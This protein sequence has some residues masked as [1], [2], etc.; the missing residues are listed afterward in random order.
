[1]NR[2][3]RLGTSRP[4]TVIR[5]SSAVALLAPAGVLLWLAW[6]LGGGPA[7]WVYLAGLALALLPGWPVAAYVFGGRHPAAWIAGAALGYPLTGL[8]LWLPLALG[9]AGPVTFAGVW[10]VGTVLLWGVL[11]PRRAARIALPAWTSRDTFAFALVLLLVPLIVGRPFTRI[12]EP[13]AD[14]AR[15][16]RAYFTADFL[17][18]MALTAELEKLERQPHNPYVAGEPL[19]YYWLHFVPPA[20]AATVAGK[21][22]PDRVGRLTINATGTG[23]IFLGSLFL[24]VWASSEARAAA[25][26]LATALAV[27]ASSAEG[28]FLIYDHI[29]VNAPLGLIRNMNVDAV[30]A[31]FFGAFTIDGLQRALLYNPH[32]SMAAA[33]G[34]VALTIAA[35]ADAALMAGVA[36][37]AGVALGL[38]F[39]LS[40]FPGA[41]LVA[42][43]G[44]SCFIQILAS[45]AGLRA[46]V[47]LALS[48]LPVAA[49]FGW[50]VLNQTFEGGPGNLHFG[51]YSA[52][53]AMPVGAL[54][55]AAGPALAP[56]LVGLA[57]LPS[58]W[59]RLLPAASGLGLALCLI[60]FVHLRS[61]MI[62]IGWR[63]GQILLLCA[64]ALSAAGLAALTARSRTAAA[65]FVVAVAAIGLPTTAIDLFN[66]QDVENRARSSGFAWTLRVTPGEWEAFEWLRRRTPKDAVVQVDPITRGRD[67]WTIVPSFAE[68]RMAAG[69]PISL[70]AQP[71]YH[72]LS[73]KVRYLYSTADAAEAWHVARMLQINYLVVGRVERDEYPGIVARLDEATDYFLRRFVNDD[74]HIYRVR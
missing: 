47:R 38:A 63:A 45:R 1:M 4:H 59:R 35:S 73:E 30:T 27:L 24:F 50:C 32:H 52:A 31:W 7:G 9:V 41:C 18:H 8:L 61:E 37:A 14:G 46:I 58:R 48:A 12:G 2:S 15:Q 49:A 22:L 70:L 55:L 17:W 56:A 33:S 71:Q 54:L 42:I 68:R 44:F 20:A 57:V 3:L 67:S 43:F 28:L 39:M 53:R 62:W 25:A 13:D 72:E 40:P 5:P 16:F 6:R 69:L 11:W 36:L 10:L 23:T 21:W 74:V 66:A 51:F 26:A 34:L 64:A 60:Y 29:R 65:I 19:K